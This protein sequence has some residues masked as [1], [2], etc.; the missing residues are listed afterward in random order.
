VTPEIGYRLAGFCDGEG[1]FGIVR[2]KKPRTGSVIYA[3]VFALHVRDDD[4]GA[5]ERYQEA[6]GLGVIYNSGPRATPQIAANP[7]VMWRIHRKR[8]CL[9]LV[10]IFETYPLWTKKARDFEIWAKAVRY[11]NGDKPLGWAPMESWWREIR[12]VREYEAPE[13]EALDVELAT[14]FD[15]AI[16]DKEPGSA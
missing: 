5:V 7:V 16:F 10:Q 6:T 3:C 1:H 11:L 9:S 2:Q 14:L 8:D 12:E 4:T 13:H 15:D